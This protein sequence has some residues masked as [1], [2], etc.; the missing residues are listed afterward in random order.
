MEKNN[1]H[2]HLALQPPAHSK[3]LL[4]SSDDSASSKETLAPKTPKTPTSGEI[5]IAGDVKPPPPPP[6]PPMPVPGTEDDGTARRQ[7]N[8]HPGYPVRTSSASAVPVLRSAKTPTVAL[9]P[10]S[11]PG[12]RASPGATSHFTTTMTTATPTTATATTTT[13]PMR[14]AP[15]PAGPLPPAPSRL[16]PRKTSSYHGPEQYDVVGGDVRREVPIGLQFSN[17]DGQPRY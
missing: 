12:T 16:V 7:Y 11:I 14:P 15:P 13:L 17:S 9:S 3:S 10:P 4:R 8:P 2:S 6:V 1:R 5:F